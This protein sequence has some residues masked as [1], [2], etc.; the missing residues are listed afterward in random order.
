MEFEKYM[1]LLQKYKEL[2]SGEIDKRKLYDFQ[3]NILDEIIALENLVRENEAKIKEKKERK[4]NNLQEK[5]EIGNS[6]NLMKDNIFHLKGDIIRVKE[7][8]DALAYTLFSKFD[9]K[10]FH[11]CGCNMAR[12]GN[13]AT[14]I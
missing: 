5:I 1:E 3:I 10:N 11:L 7:I 6:I 8:M 4:A 14:E 2:C 12:S 9:L 13:K